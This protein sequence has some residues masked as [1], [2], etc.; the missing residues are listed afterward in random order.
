MRSQ[1]ERSAV[2][3]PKLQM[4]TLGKSRKRRRRQSVKRRAKANCQIERRRQRID[5]GRENAIRSYNG[6]NNRSES[7]ALRD[8]PIR[9]SASASATLLDLHAR[10][11]AISLG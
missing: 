3:P 8:S 7:F 5:F 9:R 10:L 6:S 1:P 4:P 11:G 2:L